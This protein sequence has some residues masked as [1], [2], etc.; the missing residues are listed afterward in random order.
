VR[1][2]RVPK[3]AKKRSRNYQKKEVKQEGNARKVT[4]DMTIKEFQW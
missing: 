3:E 4:L 1:K 2:R